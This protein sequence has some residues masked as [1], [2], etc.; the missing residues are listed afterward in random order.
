MRRLVYFAASLSALAGFAMSAHAD[1]LQ[2]A[3]RAA[4]STNPQLDAQRAQAEIAEEQ[5]VAARGAR[6]PTVEVNGQYGPE[7]VTTNRSLVLDVGGRQIASAQVQAVQPIYA[8]GRILAGIR[9]AQAGIDASDAELEVIRQDT[10]LQTVTAYVDVRR[11][12]ETLAIRQGS[13]DLL[14]EQYRAANDRFEVGEITRTDVAL[15]EARLESAR[16][17]FALSEA[18]IEGSEANFAFLVGYSP[19]E[20]AAPPELTNMP[21]AFEEALEIALANN[22][23]IAAAEHNERVAKEQIST[24]RARL[25]PE[26]NVVA[27][28]AIQGTLNQPDSAPSPFGPG[29]PTPDFSD[30]NVSAFAQARVPLYQGGVARSQVRSAKLERTQAKLQI[31][32]VRRQTVAQVATAWHSFRAAMIGIEASQRGVAAAEIAFEGGKEELI[33]G[34]RTTLDVLDQEQDLLEARLS[35]IEAE[36]DAYVAAHQ[37]LR[38][39]GQLSASRFGL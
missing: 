39:M 31:E 25:R 30:R 7:R 11:D 9:S 2:D 15:A 21:R 28:A 36:R 37:L 38:A 3:L 19:D 24:A 23:D 5:L 4:N 34:V 27:S 35:V 33:V 32:V 1:T 16:A 10:F 22:P 6:L 13:V 26:V 17:N 18:Q 12:R 29:G 14:E 20:L 8:G